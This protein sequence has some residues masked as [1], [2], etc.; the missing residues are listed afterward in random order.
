MKQSQ[1]IKQTKF[2]KR[3][4]YFTRDHEWIDFQGSIAYTGVCPFKLKGIKNIDKIVFSQSGIICKAG[5][6]IGSIYYAD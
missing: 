2:L 3:N 1:T 6:T 4:L 5:D